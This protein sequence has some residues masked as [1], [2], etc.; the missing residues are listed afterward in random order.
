MQ[1]GAAIRGAAIRGAAI[2]GASL[3]GD[4]FAAQPEKL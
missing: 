2:R 1:V 3:W 4:V